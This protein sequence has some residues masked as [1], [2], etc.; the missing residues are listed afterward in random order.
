[1]QNMCVCRNIFITVLE[2]EH[3]S[4][5]CRH[6]DINHVF[7]IFDVMLILPLAKSCVLLCLIWPWMS[8]DMQGHWLGL[9]QSTKKQ[10][11]SEEEGNTTKFTL[12][13]CFSLQLGVYLP[14]LF[15]ISQAFSHPSWQI[16]ALQVQSPTQM[17]MVQLQHCH[18]WLLTWTL[19][20]NKVR[21][22]H[23]CNH[24]QLHTE[25]I[26]IHTHTKHF[27]RNGSMVL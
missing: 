3:L 8:V 15:C 18:E 25:Y 16:G 11:M 22:I 7:T 1:M 5:I 2:R 14:P 21:D 9:S 6:C 20:Q 4:P 19:T 23:R 12:G 26:Q 13:C 24:Q 27:H 17:V 10:I